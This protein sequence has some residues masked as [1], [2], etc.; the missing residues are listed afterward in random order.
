[1][2]HLQYRRFKIFALRMARTCFRDS[3]AP[4]TAWIVQHVQEFI[5]GLEPE[6]IPCIRSWDCSDPY[7]EGSPY[8]RLL[9]TY[10]CP[11]R[12]GDTYLNLP[13]SF[14]PD[15]PSC[16]GTGEAQEFAAPSC[17]GDIFSG[18]KTETFYYSLRD[19]M[20]DAE[21]ER[22]WQLRESEADDADEED[23][24]LVTDVEDRWAGPVASCVRAALDVASEPSA[25]VLG[26]TAGDVRRMY[27]P[28]PVPRWV[29]DFFRN[30]ETVHA[31]KAIPWIGFTL[32][33]ER[34]PCGD[35]DG[36]ADDDELWL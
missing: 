14:Q 35:F 12:Y 2:T 26:M 29:K 33:E 34:E 36:F 9:R 10:V 11:C 13:G 30:G 27:A 28:K 4:D 18:W 5:R 8:R 3:A 7:P 31:E 25:G 22:H 21:W 16:R 24:D 20:T 32:A 6:D 17:L 15:C 23:E 1:M 19:Y